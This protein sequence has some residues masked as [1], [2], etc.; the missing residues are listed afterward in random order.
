MTII[1]FQLTDELHLQ[2]EQDGWCSSAS[3]VAG[4][5]SDKGRDQKT[6]DQVMKQNKIP[7]KS[8]NVRNQP[9]QQIWNI[10]LETW[11]VLYCFRPDAAQRAIK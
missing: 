9:R 6:N 8:M 3:I 10:I 5:S 11:N 4:P 7:R 2:S 1:H